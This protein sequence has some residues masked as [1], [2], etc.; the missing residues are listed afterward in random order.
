MLG[1]QVAQVTS[2]EPDHAGGC[3]HQGCERLWAPPSQDRGCWGGG[4]W[5]AVQEPQSLD[6]DSIQ[7][8][9][10]HTHTHT[11]SLRPRPQGPLSAFQR[12]TRSHAHKTVTC[13]AKP[14]AFEIVDWG[15][16]VLWV[17]GQQ[18]RCLSA[19]PVCWGSELTGHPTRRLRLRLRVAS[20]PGESPAVSLAVGALPARLRPRHRLVLP[21]SLWAPSAFMAWTRDLLPAPPAP[22]QGPPQTVHPDRLRGQSSASSS[23]SH[24]IS[25]VQAADHFPAHHL[26]LLPQ[27]LAPASASALGPC[28]SQCLRVPRITDLRPLSAVS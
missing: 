6:Q 5:R 20:L 18:P 12:P 4:G 28:T 25:T 16:G 2:P 17:R 7:V 8:T 27:P 13:S 24:V 22:S 1:P 9:P 21:L 3:Q 14:S 26:A 11:A 19:E 10:S 23:P 15:P